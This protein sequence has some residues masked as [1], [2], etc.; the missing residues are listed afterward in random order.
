MESLGVSVFLC[1]GWLGSAARQAV[2]LPARSGKSVSVKNCKLI[3][4]DFPVVGRI[5]PIGCDIAQ[6]KP[7]QFR[8]RLISWEVP[9][10]LDDFS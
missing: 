9:S 7:Y 4:G 3:H 2:A 10:S 1:S 6:P 5:T 8:C